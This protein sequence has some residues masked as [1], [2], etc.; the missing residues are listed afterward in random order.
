MEKVLVGFWCLLM[1][2]LLSANH[3]LG[4]FTGWLWLVVIGGSVVV[5]LIVGRDEPER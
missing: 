4:F 3:L 1:A 2:V 5:T